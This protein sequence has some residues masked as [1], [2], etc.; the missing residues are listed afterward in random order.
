MYTCNVCVYCRE[1]N[2]FSEFECHYEM[3]IDV[4]YHGVAYKYCV[5]NSPYDESLHGHKYRSSQNR[6]LRIRQQGMH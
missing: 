6:Y 5:T 1:I 2:N 4:L 3:D